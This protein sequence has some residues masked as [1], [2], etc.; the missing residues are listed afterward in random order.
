MHDTPDASLLSQCQLEI[1]R[2]WTDAQD[3]APCIVSPRRTSSLRISTTSSR[4]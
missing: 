2:A 3:D 4:T 1:E